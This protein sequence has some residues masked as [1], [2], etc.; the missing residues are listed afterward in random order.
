MKAFWL[1]K[2]RDVAA[3]LR[4][5]EEMRMR[6]LEMVDA[7]EGRIVGGREQHR[8]LA[9]KLTNVLT[10]R[11]LQKP[12]D[13]GAFYLN[14][15]CAVHCMRKVLIVFIIIYIYYYTSLS[16]FLSNIVLT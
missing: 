16:L 6:W 14:F 15:I 5:R 12:F 1:W 2:C 13:S 8:Q 3:C 4:E 11:M 7:K 10:Y 9:Y